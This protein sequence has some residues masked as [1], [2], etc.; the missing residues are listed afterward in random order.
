M[1]VFC[2]GVLFLERKKSERERALTREYEE[3]KVCFES[4]KRFSH[5][6][7]TH[8]ES[9]CCARELLLKLLRKYPNKFSVSLSL[10]ADSVL[11][12]RKL[13][14]RNHD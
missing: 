4:F 10:G 9:S 7:E 13:F 8:V 14:S 6:I 12:T 5:K 11:K 2:L 3:E 1:S